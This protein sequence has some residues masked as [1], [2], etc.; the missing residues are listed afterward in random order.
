MKTVEHHEASAEAGRQDKAGGS[1]GD[2]LK[3][4]LNLCVTEDKLSDYVGKPLFISDRLYQGQL[5]PGTVTGL[6]WTS[7]GGAV[8]YV[9]ATALP[10]VGAA[11]QSVP[12]SLGITGQLGSVMKESSQIGLLVAR[13]QLQKRAPA[14]RVKFFEENE[15]HI[16]FPEGAQPKDGPSAGVTIV[17][18]L[19]S[20]GF[21]RPVRS[22]LAMTGEISLNG[23]VLPV[24][25]IKEKT[26]AARRAGCQALLFPQ[27]NQRD[28]DELPDYLRDGLEVHFVEEYDEVV[29]IAFPEL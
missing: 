15:L 27:A 8:L 14:D 25:G 3:E 11:G 22:D 6:A 18:A 2:S 28:F 16:H 20:L 9:E 1:S 13:K 4:E 19:L 12:P 23:K 10:R 5:P 21:D 7:M 26:I 24:G 17:S 29:S